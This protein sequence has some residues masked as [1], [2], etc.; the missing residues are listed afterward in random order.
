LKVKIIGEGPERPMVQS[1]LQEHLSD[2]SVELLPRLSQAKWHEVLSQT[3]VFVSCARDFNE[4]FS[5]NTA[6]ALA[7]GC[8]V[9]VTRCSGI[10]HYLEDQNEAILTDPN[11]PKSLS[12]MIHSG[13]LAP[14]SMRESARMAA[15]QKFDQDRM[16]SQYESVILR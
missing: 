7:A 8:K 14:E 9:V 10:A 5:L 6:E 2:Y 16:L 4:T 12:K 1:Y 15:R 11:D 3:D 13:L